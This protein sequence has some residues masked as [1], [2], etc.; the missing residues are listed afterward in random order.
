MWYNNYYYC[1]EPLTVPEIS[2]LLPTTTNMMKL[3]RVDL[4]ELCLLYR[5][6]MQFSISN[7]FQLFV[8]TR[9]CSS[10]SHLVLC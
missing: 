5:Q 9:H 4:S 1:L 2:E 3:V 7:D 8:Q 10:F 6:Q